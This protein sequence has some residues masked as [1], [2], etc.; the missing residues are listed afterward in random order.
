MSDQAMT[1][2]QMKTRPGEAWGREK[3]FQW[4]CMGA[5]IALA[6]FVYSP[7][8]SFEYVWDD[9]LLFLESSDLRPGAF[10]LR[11]IFEPILVESTYFRPVVLL[12]MV[13][14]FFTVG[15]NSAVS[16]GVNILIF[17]INALL[18]FFLGKAM[19]R[20]CIGGVYAVPAAMVGALAY[21]LSPVNVEPVAWVAGRFDLMVTT[22]VLLA[23]YFGLFGRHLLTT[24]LLSPLCFFLA[25]LCKEMAITMPVLLLLLAWAKASCTDEPRPSGIWGYLKGVALSPRERGR[26]LAYAAAFLVY[27][28]LRA[29]FIPQVVHADKNQL[30]YLT[31]LTWF[32]FIGHTELFYLKKLLFPFMSLGPHHPFDISKFPPLKL[33]IGIGMP[34]VTAMLIWVTWKKSVL[35]A[36]FL[37]AVLV[38]FLP[39]LNI[40]PLTIGGSIGHERFLLMP[41]ALAAIGL[42]TGT[43]F[44]LERLRASPLEDV[45]AARH[46]RMS[47]YVGVVILVWIVVSGINARATLPL[48]GNNYA[49][50]K[51]AY[52]KYP[53]DGYA[54]FM[55]SV[56]A[57]D[58]G[59]VDEYLSLVE[60]PPS[61]ADDALVYSSYLK[62]AG[63][64]EE[65]VH[66]LKQIED[67]KG[68]R[69]TKQPVYNIQA[70]CYL[71]LKQYDDALAVIDKNIAQF[72][73]FTTAYTLRSLALYGLGKTD[74]AN[75]AYEEAMRRV[76]PTEHRF[77]K[78]YREG[79]LESIKPSAARP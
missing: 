48:W 77:W 32:A 11:R 72:P 70:D 45:S 55:H 54:R 58:A 56:T 69:F 1:M 7:A 41:S 35:A 79:F 57:L 23:L 9:R 17:T 52:A 51:W 22:F 63:R 26:Y 66:I 71:R 38:A 39:V 42:A 36:V 34:I 43:G 64:C 25:L 29:Y 65:A 59:Y 49:L 12:T 47:L 68:T 78:E 8:L 74:E 16:H 21:L 10:R 46:K 60:L 75:A 2:M 27:L 61:N 73:T 62:G 30:Q 5:L 19:V 28:I 50:W 14:E 6:I 3:V 33:A 44:L 67:L 4:L 18:V 31:P 13:A 37:M 15:V 20:T 40:I 24:H 76:P 53:E